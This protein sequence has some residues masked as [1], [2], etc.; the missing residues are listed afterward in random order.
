MLKRRNIREVAIQLLYFRALNND[1]ETWQT[2]E[3]FWNLTQETSIKK[4]DYARAKAVLHVAQGRENKLQ[5]LIAQ[6]PK[7]LALLQTSPDLAPFVKA[8][9]KITSSQNLLSGEIETLKAAVKSKG[10]DN[11][12]AELITKVHQA[13]QGIE[14]TNQA[15]HEHL[16]KHPSLV[17]KLEATTAAIKHLTSASARLDAIDDSDST[18]TDFAHLR[19]SSSEIQI[20]RKT[21][22]ELVNNVTSQQED[23]DSILNET[24]EN[25]KPERVNLVDRAILQLAV[26]EIQHCNDIPRAVSINE[27]IEI[28]KSYGTTD[29]SRFVNGVLDA[30]K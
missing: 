13:N 26:Y 15:W 24:I 16:A 1:E 20:A 19:A 6:A 11:L 7:T 23:I 30:I 28:A 9:K 14:A 29:S 22:K 17:N 27:A 18:L 25:F 8:F 2:E 10:S 12:P 21:V 4:L 5:K 3:D